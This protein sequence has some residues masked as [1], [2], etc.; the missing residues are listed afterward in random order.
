[1]AEVAAEEMIS[2]RWGHPAFVSDLDVRYLSQVRVGPVRTISTWLGDEP[3]S[4]VRVELHDLT[5]G[6]LLAHALARATLGE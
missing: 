1:V 5:T 3:G 2:A 6:V 4:W